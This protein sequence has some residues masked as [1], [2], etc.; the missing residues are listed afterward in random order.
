MGKELGRKEETIEREDCSEPAYVTLPLE[1]TIPLSLLPSVQTRKEKEKRRRIRR[2]NR[3]LIVIAF[4]KR[5]RRIKLRRWR[6]RERE[7]YTS[8]SFDIHFRFGTSR[9]VR[10]SDG[11][12]GSVGE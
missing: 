5:G 10:N 6:E 8:G 11:R 7:K 2:S 1:L 3:L 4:R 12:S 9:S